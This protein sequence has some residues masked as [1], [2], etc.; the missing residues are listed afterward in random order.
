MQPELEVDVRLL[1]MVAK[2]VDAAAA[3]LAAAVAAAGSGLAPPASSAAAA[4]ARVAEQGWLGE[5]RRVQQDTEMFAADLA[6]AGK[7]YL[8]SDQDSAHELRMV[9][10]EGPR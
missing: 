10:T 1:A 3:T 5:L 9:G 6:V 2:S 4:A 7:S 8:A